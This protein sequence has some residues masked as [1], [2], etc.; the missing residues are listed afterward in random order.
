MSSKPARATIVVVALSHA[1]LELVEGTLRESGYR[2]LATS[3][4]AEAM[5]LA[6]SVAIDLLIAERL[7]A[8][9]LEGEV[10]L[11]Q[12]SVR[13]LRIAARDEARAGDLIQPFALNELERMVAQAL[14]E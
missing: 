11:L 4:V 12:P 10:R 3:D 5:L 14:G 9:L 7:S 13:L 6:Q 8:F 1:A 2:V